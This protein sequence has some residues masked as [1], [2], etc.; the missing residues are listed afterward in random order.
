MIYSV[1]SALYQ[2]F[3]ISKGKSSGS[4]TFESG[5]K[6]MTVKERGSGMEDGRSG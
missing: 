2:S 1:D 5:G 3:L 4:K 6:K